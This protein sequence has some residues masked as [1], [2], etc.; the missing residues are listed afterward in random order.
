MRLTEFYKSVAKNSEYPFVIRFIVLTA[1]SWIFQGV[2]YMDRTEKTFKIVTELIILIFSIA[3][4]HGILSI[5]NAI[6]ISLIF[7]HT[8]NWIFNGQIFVVL[9][10]L[11]MVMNPPECFSR[12]VE[13]L[14][15]RIGAERL[16]HSCSGI[17]EYFQETIRELV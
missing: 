8:M 10:N 14:T 16:H 3:L 9:K 12:Y 1:S 13:D 5:I 11:K 7:C 17:R 15:E 4:L 2:L 6:I